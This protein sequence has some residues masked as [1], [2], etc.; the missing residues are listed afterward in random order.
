MST[1]VGS[2]VSPVF[3]E[4]SLAWARKRSSL[5]QREA[6]CTTT[7]KLQRSGAGRM[8]SH[9]P[10]PRRRVR[11]TV[12]PWRPWM[13]SAT[14]VQAS[15]RGHSGRRSPPISY[16]PGASHTYKRRHA[17]LLRGQARKSERASASGRCGTRGCEPNAEKWTA[18]RCMVSSASARSLGRAANRSCR[19]ACT[20]RASS[21]RVKSY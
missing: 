5:T 21:A 4:C 13:A 10:P 8:R 3:A 17:P 16:E 20:C 19:I 6:A 12:P 11:V 1:R 18:L 9:Y 7:R 14:F 2:C 15:G